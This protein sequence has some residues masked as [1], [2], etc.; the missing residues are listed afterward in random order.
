MFSYNNINNNI[1]TGE[2]NFVEL[3]KN[4]INKILIMKNG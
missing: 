4:N 2:N 1:E 3:G